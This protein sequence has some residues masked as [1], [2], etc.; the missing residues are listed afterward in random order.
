M[1]SGMNLIFELGVIGMWV[2]KGN[3]NQHK[4]LNFLFFPLSMLV[5]AQ[6]QG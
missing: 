2:P 3:V 5:Y 4:T 6:K 1:D